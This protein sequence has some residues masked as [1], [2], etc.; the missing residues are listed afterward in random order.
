MGGKPGRKWGPLRSEYEELG[1]LAAVLRDVADSHGVTLRDLENRMPHGKTAISENLNGAKRPE[2]QFVVAFLKACAGGDRHGLFELERKVQPLWEA[3]GKGLARRTPPVATTSDALVPVDVRTWAAHLHETAR[4]LQV[5]TELQSSVNRNFSLVHGLTYVMAQISSAVTTLTTERDALRKEL[6]AREADTRELHQ[7][8]QVLDHTHRRLAAAERLQTEMAGRLYEALRQR[9]EAENL[10]KEAIAQAEMAR[11]RLAELEDGAVAFTSHPSDSEEAGNSALPDL[12]GPADQAIANEILRRVD[13][14]LGDE[15]ANLSALHAEVIGGADAASHIAEL[16]AGQSEPDASTSA[17]NER[18]GRTTQS[19]SGPLSHLRPSDYSKASG[20]VSRRL[21]H[22]SDSG[23]VT[24]VCGQ[25]PADTRGPLAYPGNPNYSELTSFA[26]PDALMEL[27][28]HVRAENPMMDI[29]TRVSSQVSR[30]DLTGHM[31][32]LGPIMWNEI[33]AQPLDIARLRVRQMEDPELMTGEIFVAEVDGME[34]KFLPK[35]GGDRQTMIEDVGFLSRMPN[36]LNSSRTLTICNGI[37]SRGV[38]GT[39][40]SL[41]DARLRESNMQYIEQ[42]FGED[43]HFGILMRIPVI[44]GKTM[45]PDFASP[46]TVLYQW[47][48]K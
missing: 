1:E 25:L 14:S 33:S 38:L 37:H 5:V 42:A 28:G 12:M 23:P 21:W 43:P 27:Y 10:K 47:S 32:L 16:S 18:Q 26:D 2:W 24:I 8:R 15:A 30:D 48:E 46:G 41:P 17:D 19:A 20:R 35:W 22:F 31:V 3:A 11:R 6:A 7:T 45:T 9:E 44:T 39:V 13:T 34:R 36:P 40:R 4:I 29:L